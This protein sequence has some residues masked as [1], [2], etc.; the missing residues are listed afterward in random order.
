MS[1]A[2]ALGGA[3]MKLAVVFLGLGLAES[4]V[5]PSFLQTRARRSYLHS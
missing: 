2:K 3:D 4:S 1:V 5:R